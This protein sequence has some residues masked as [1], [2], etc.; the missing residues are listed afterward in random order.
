MESNQL[1]NLLYGYKEVSDSMNDLM[2]TLL[3]EH[4]VS[5]EK[6]LENLY[7]ELNLLAGQLDVDF[8][9]RINTPGL[10]GNLKNYD[11]TKGIARLKLHLDILSK[12]FNKQ[13]IDTEY[14]QQLVK[15]FEEKKPDL[16]IP[17]VSKQQSLLGKLLKNDKDN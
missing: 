17:N 11:I 15:V 16:K 3:A 1:L 10:Q 6:G 4:E 13:N 5:Q 8:F 12:V 9:E 7:A 2:I 14:K